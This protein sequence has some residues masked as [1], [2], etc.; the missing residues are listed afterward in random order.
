[1]PRKVT[2]P[3]EIRRRADEQYRL[4]EGILR[5]RDALKREIRLTD[6]ATDDLSRRS[7]P[8][9]EG[10]GFSRQ[11]GER[12]RS[13]LESF[14]AQMVVNPEKA[15][16]EY[17]RWSRAWP[18]ARDE[19][20]ASA[21]SVVSQWLKT[22]DRPLAGAAVLCLRDTDFER[23]PRVGASLTRRPHK[24]SVRTAADLDRLAEH[25]SVKAAMNGDTQ[26]R[27]GWQ[28]AAIALVTM[29]TGI[30]EETIRRAVR[31]RKIKTPTS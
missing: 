1:M 13:A 9:P 24:W 23:R 14:E 22:R 28:N 27:P 4:A 18:S 30:G 16:D 21:V 2:D 8:S 19:M 15:I 5:I 7:D 17:E 6:G 26:R 29:A 20:L 3:H 12:L 11:R 25:G 31:A 10:V